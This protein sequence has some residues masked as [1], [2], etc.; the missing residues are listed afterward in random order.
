MLT[1][2]TAEH[3]G[4]KPL[5][6]QSKK[7]KHVSSPR[8]A[9][10]ICIHFI[11]FISVHRERERERERERMKYLEGRSTKATEQGGLK[12]EATEAVTR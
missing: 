10:C 11:F 4:P 7:I 6:H 8:H 1:A 2:T 5:A 3:P 12:A 9:T